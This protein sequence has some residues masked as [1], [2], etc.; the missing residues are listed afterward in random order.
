[1]AW[2]ITTLLFLLV[3]MN[4]AFS[5]S[6]AFGTKAYTKLVPGFNKLLST[7]NEN[8]TLVLIVGM[9]EDGTTWTDTIQY[10]KDANQY[11]VYLF[12]WSK[13]SKPQNIS[14]EI[15]LGLNSIQADHSL[16]NIKVMAHSAGGVLLLDSLCQDKCHFQKKADNLSFFT[17]ASPLGGYGNHIPKIMKYLIAPV[18]I[19]MG[20]RITFSPLNKEIN[21]TI[22]MTTFEAD[23][24]MKEKKDYDIRFPAFK[25]EE[26]YEKVILKDTTHNG[27][28]LEGLKYILG[29]ES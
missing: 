11:N 26:H 15:A 19:K 29:E 5:S 27:A 8:D 3:S 4:P 18:T 1:M 16:A 22:L 28:I 21:L 13:R 6:S 12:K 24:L 10:L 17:V 9:N 20:K 7:E 23:H 25:D 2:M 14:K